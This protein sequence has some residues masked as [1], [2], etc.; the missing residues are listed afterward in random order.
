MQ[1]YIQR[2]DYVSKFI[3]LNK[4]IELNF[5]EMRLKTGRKPGKLVYIMLYISHACMRTHG[6][7][8]GGGPG[9]RGGAAGR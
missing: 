8:G 2:G 9:A 4:H 7:G 5:N 1:Y 3:A 6:G